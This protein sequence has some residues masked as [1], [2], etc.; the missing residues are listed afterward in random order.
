LPLGVMKVGLCFHEHWMRFRFDS[1]AMV[2][3]VI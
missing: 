3:W 1:D 2:N